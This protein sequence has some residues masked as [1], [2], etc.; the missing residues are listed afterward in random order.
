VNRAI[1]DVVRN[2][3][4]RLPL[5]AAAARARFPPFHFH[6][7]F[8]A[9]VGE[10]VGRFAKRSRLERAIR[11]L[12]HRRRRSLTE[13]ALACGFASSSDVS[14]SFEQRDGVPPSAL[15]VAA[16]R[17]RRHE[18]LA[19][20]AAIAEGRGRPERLPAGASPDG[21]E[22]RLR[23]LPARTVACVRVP[24]PYGGGVVEAVRRLV[25]WAESRGQADRRWLGYP[26]DDP[27]IVVLEDRRHDVAVEADRVELE[28]DVGRFEFPA[29]KVVRIG[30]FGG[31][32]LELR[33]L[34]RL[35]G[36]W[37]PRIPG[38]A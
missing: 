27:E 25:A 32:D 22:V 34:G 33:A 14:R 38:R 9:L 12:S 10:T 21:L 31:V 24:R 35:Y 17:A 11:A 4:R 30:M 37:L 18:D 2:P 23:D 3:D 5:E 20:S 29:M 15:D 6:R 1:D 19:V 26:S 36:T 16:W 28:G 8:R 7:I 13:I